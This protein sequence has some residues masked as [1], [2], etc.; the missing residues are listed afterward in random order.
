MSCH[1]C[2]LNAVDDC[3]GMLNADPHLKGLRLHRNPLLGKPPQGIPGGVADDQEHVITTDLL[4]CR[5]DDASHDALFDEQL[6]H[7]HIESKLHPAA[8]QIQP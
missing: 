7:A 1:L 6:L 2:I 3:L 8:L 5:T 4:S